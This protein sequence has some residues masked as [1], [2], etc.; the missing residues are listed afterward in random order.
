M[1]SNQTK[2][3]VLSWLLLSIVGLLATVLSIHA[4]VF[5]PVFALSVAISVVMLSWIKHNKTFFS[6]T[7]YRWSWYLSLVFLLFTLLSVVYWF[8]AGGMAQ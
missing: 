2:I 5:Q 6:Q 3:A 7:F 8:Q 4:N 1:N